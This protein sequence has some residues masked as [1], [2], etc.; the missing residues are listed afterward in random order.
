MTDAEKY[1]LVVNTWTLATAEVEEALMKRLSED[2]AGFNPVFMLID[3]GA[4]GSRT[5]AAQIGGMRGLM[6]KPQRR[7]VGEEVIETPIKS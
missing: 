6:A 5:Q 2:Q 7:S 1:N 3:S 4:R